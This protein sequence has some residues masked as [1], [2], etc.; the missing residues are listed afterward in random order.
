MPTTDNISVNGSL[1]YLRVDRYW[2]CYDERR[3]PL[4]EGAMGTVYLGYNC[5]TMEAVAIK[6]INDKYANNPI[7]RQLAM[8]E[9]RYLY[10]HPNLVEMI[11]CCTQYRD[12]GPIFTVSKFVRGE[13]AD[14][15]VKRYINA[16]DDEF[17]IPRVVELM[18]PVLDALDYLHSN[19][20]IHCDIKPSNIIVENGKNV[21]LMDLGISIQHTANQ[22]CANL[23]AS[24]T[25]GTPLY[26][27]PEQFVNVT[28]VDTTTDI[29][30]VGVT[31]YELL[32]GYNPFK[33]SSLKETANKHRSLELP[34]S[35]R[36]TKPVLEVLRIAT[37]PEQSRRF[38]SALEM[39]HALEEALTI[40]ES[41]WSR[42]I[43]ALIVA[44]TIIVGAMITLFLVLWNN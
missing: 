36:I 38:G 9:A 43:I 21:R 8:Q 14:N 16:L 27:A 23:S 24:G 10:R 41:R 2:Y 31:L 7:I 25:M 44:I 12:S 6:R 42:N 34:E 15:Y 32:A 20:V 35:D 22:G 40:K 26:A 37:D 13:N 39:K 33:G 11:G 4:G 3:T 29:Y 28:K 30:E 17:R 1:I 5:S 18:Y 19:G